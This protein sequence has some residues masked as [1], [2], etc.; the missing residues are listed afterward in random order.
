MHFICRPFIGKNDQS[1]W[2]QYWENEPDD[3]QK[4]T[5]G[6]LFGLINIKNQQS[7]PIT[8]GRD[9]IFEINQLYFTQESEDINL[10]LKNSLTLL[11]QNPIFL[12]YKIDVSLMVVFNN[13]VYL[14]TLGTN[15]CLL[16]RNNQIS[17][18]I[19]GQEGQIISS[20]GPILENDRFLLTSLNFLNVITLEKIKTILVETKIQNIEENILSLINSTPNQ[21]QVSAVLIECHQDEV[22][23]PEV[24]IDT[25]IP[26]DES[27]LEVKPSN[28]IADNLNYSQKP[29]AIYVQHQPNFKTSRRKKTQLIV[30]IVLIFCLSLSIYYGNQKNK[31]IKTESNYISLKTELEQ[32]LTNINTVKGLD[33]DAAVKTAQEAKIIVDKMVSLNIHQPDVSQYKSQIDSLLFQTGSSEALDPQVVQDTSFIVSQPQFSHLYFFNNNLF[34]LD[35]SKGRLDSLNPQNKSSQNLIISE[36]VKSATHLLFSNNSLYL[37]KDNILSLVEKNNLQP[38]FDFNSTGASLTITDVDF[39]NGSLYVLDNQNQSIWKLSPNSTGFSTPQKWLK[40]DAKLEIGTNS[41]AIDGQ[42]WVLNHS[43]QIELYTS[44]VKD[45][46]SQKTNIN[47]TKAT[48]LK[49]DPESDFLIFGDN[50]EFIYVYRKNGEYYSKYNLSKFKVVDFAF[51]SVNKI[52]YFLSFDQKIYQITL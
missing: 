27:L 48:S 33:L 23:P 49:T 47:F 26:Q 46:F 37:L 22:T 24:L 51:D 4:F 7:E 9:I 5:K 36:S 21:N 10:S 8:I 31:A 3:D 12:N 2:S 30:A 45:K 1:L 50:S 38:K 32:K 17:I 34:L 42:V 35:S 39:W 20:C 44:G 40:N 6:H 18:L 16:Q 25:P 14:A 43:G 11:S 52:I 29:D 28:I 41:L 19:N 13:Q 15:N